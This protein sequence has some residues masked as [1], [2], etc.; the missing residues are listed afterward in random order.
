MNSIVLVALIALATI[1]TQLY[2][3]TVRA[4]AKLGKS[5]NCIS[6]T[7]RY[8]AWSL[9]LSPSAAT[10]ATFAAAPSAGP[11]TVEPHEPRHLTATTSNL[12]QRHPTKEM[13]ASRSSS[14]LVPLR[15]L[16]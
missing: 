10:T 13:G 16:F 8:V 4:Y 6:I 5:H 15:P 1:S 2:L 14:F 11:G 7:V 9:Q 3:Y 12:P